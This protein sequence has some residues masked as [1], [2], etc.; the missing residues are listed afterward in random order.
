MELLVGLESLAQDVKHLCLNRCL[1]FDSVDCDLEL[2]DVL[3]NGVSW[4]GVLIDG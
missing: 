2:V 3:S 4:Q 1:G